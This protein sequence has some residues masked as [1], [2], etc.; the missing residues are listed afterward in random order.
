MGFMAINHRRVTDPRF[1]AENVEIQHHSNGSASIQCVTC[2]GTVLTQREL[3]DVAGVPLS[4]LVAFLNRRTVRPDV[5]TK[6]RAT[7][8]AVHPPS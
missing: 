3:A 8:K 4:S 2:H 1:V 7:V 5:A 6:I